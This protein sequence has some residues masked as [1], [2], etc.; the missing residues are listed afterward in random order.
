MIVMNK[1]SFNGR[2]C[3]LH[4]KNISDCVMY[5]DLQIYIRRQHTVVYV[6]LYI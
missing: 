1:K 2:H 6:S 3:Y 5:A 4:S